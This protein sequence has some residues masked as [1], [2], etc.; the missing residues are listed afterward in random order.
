MQYRV[1]LTFILCSNVGVWS[2][3][4]DDEGSDLGGGLVTQ[5]RNDANLDL[6]AD[7]EY[8]DLRAELLAYHSALATLSSR[9]S[10]LSTP[11]WKLGGICVNYKLCSGARYMTEVPGC[12]DKLNV[13]CFAWNRFQVKDMRDKGINNV[14]MPWSIHQD[15]GG[16]GILAGLDEPDSDSEEKKGTKPKAMKVEE[17][18]NLDREIL[19]FDEKK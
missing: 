11:C 14:A 19:I 4:N 10:L 9:R 6:S 5:L 3:D 16:K 15:V 17:F 13:C 8:E 18:K 2:E 12:K 1:L 7:E